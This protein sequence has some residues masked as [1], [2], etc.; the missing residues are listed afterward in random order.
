MGT[1]R[2][3]VGSQWRRWLQNEE[4]GLFGYQV[5][6]R[7]FTQQ[8]NKSAGEFLKEVLTGWFRW[9]DSQASQLVEGLA[10]TG[11]L[12][13]EHLCREGVILTSQDD[14]EKYQF[15]KQ[16]ERSWKVRRIRPNVPQ[17]KQ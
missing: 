1:F 6:G 16:S 11:M 13:N 8:T 17:L 14:L 3:L 4:S 5:A 7:E 15:V 12:N 9:S 2:I 10:I